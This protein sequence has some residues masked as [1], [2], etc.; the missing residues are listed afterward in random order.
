[1]LR[2][3]GVYNFLDCHHV[4]VLE[5]VAYACGV[6]ADVRLRLD[7]PSAGEIELTWGAP[8]TPPSSRRA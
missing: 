4:G 6:R 3:F 5:G 2:F 8:S 7:S 1:V